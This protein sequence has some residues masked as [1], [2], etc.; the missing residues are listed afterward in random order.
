M[1]IKDL[2]RLS[3]SRFCQAFL[4]IYSTRLLL[5]K[6]SD[7]MQQPSSYFLYV[8]NMGASNIYVDKRR[9][10]KMCSF[11]STCRVKIV[12]VKVGQKRFKFCLPRHWMTPVFIIHHF[13][14]LHWAQK[15]IYHKMKIT[16][17]CTYVCIFQL[18]FIQDKL[19]FWYFGKYCQ[20]FLIWWL[21]W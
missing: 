19:R 12:Y 16:F 13:A 3:T 8:M 15:C 5:W 9:Y 1:F 17:F 18:Y 10:F 21:S 2:V 11:L 4:M 6:Y 20:I 7:V 14:P